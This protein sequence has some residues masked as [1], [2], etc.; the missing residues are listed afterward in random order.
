MIGRSL[1]K[2][3]FATHSFPYWLQIHSFCAIYFCLYML[4]FTGVTI[5]FFITNST[6]SF[7]NVSSDKLGLLVI[8]LMS[9][10]GGILFTAL[11]HG[12]L[13]QVLCSGFQYW[14][15]VPVF[16]NMLQVNAF[17]NADDISWGTKNLD[18]R[19]DHEAVKTQSKKL[20]YRVRPTHAS[21]AFWK[22]MGD[23][24][25]HLFDQ[26]Q[27]KK[28]NARKEAKL[29]AF[30]SYLL[31][32]WVGSNVILVSII[33]IVSNTTWEECAVTESEMAV[34]AIRSQADD[35]DKALAI[36]D[37][38]QTAVT[39]LTRGS[40]LYPF[41]GLQGFPQAYPML[42]SGDA[43]AN[44]AR[45]SRVTVLANATEMFNNLDQSMPKFEDW[46]AES[47]GINASATLEEFDQIWLPMP[48][49]T[50]GFDTTITCKEE[51]GYTYYLQAQFL[52][53][54]VIVAFQ[55]G[56]SILFILGTWWRRFTGAAFG[57]GL[58]QLPDGALGMGADGK[59]LDT[60]D[61]DD[62]SS[63][64]EVSIQPT[65]LRYVTSHRGIPS[66]AD[67]DTV[68]DSGSYTP[69]SDGSMRGMRRRGSPRYI[70]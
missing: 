23:L 60:D 5:S 56:G 1:H 41:D 29:K 25:A 16:F 4:V 64:F 26:E 62:Y 53:L 13:I 68:T 40:Q 8:L 58:G 52:L 20:A 66:S 47:M 61:E 14:L 27:V 28:Y 49:N 70:D 51:N 35:Y 42:V 36:A 55:V 50:T 12:D 30:A 57:T 33:L 65:N 63:G 44:S 17:C 46:L 39:I 3:A 6:F 37:L 24:Q 69:T 2:V 59:I 18:K 38:V 45:G 19:G 10:I 67:M 32:A 15:M 54:M 11:I 22:A 21:K 34:T 7:A 48:S 31:I 9:A 43:Q